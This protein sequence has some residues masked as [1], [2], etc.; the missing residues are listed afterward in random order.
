M[1][2]TKIKVVIDGNEVTVDAQTLVS[3]LSDRLTGY[4]KHGDESVTFI[5]ESPQ[6]ETQSE[7][8]TLQQI[9]SDMMHGDN[10]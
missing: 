10:Y 9:L 7:R 2:Q 5:V 8:A 1:S 6:S 4:M 3:E